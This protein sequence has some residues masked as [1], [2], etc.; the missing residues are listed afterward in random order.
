MTMTHFTPNK[1]ANAMDAPLEEL[2]LKRIAMHRVPRWTKAHGNT[3]PRPRFSKKVL[4]PDLEVRSIIESK[5]V[6]SLEGANGTNIEP[7]ALQVDAG[8]DTPDE[9]KALIDD[10]SKLLATS[11]TLAN[12]LATTQ[13]HAGGKDRWLFVVHAEESGRPLVAVFT[14][15]AESGV[16]MDIPDDDETDPTLQRVKNLVMAESSNLKELAIFENIGAT[17]QG[18]LAK[19]LTQDATGYFLQQFLGC[20]AQED[21]SIETKKFSDGTREFLNRH[22]GSSQ[23]KQRIERALRNELISD[24]AKIEVAVFREKHI[25]PE[26]R[27]GF[28]EVMKLRGLADRE[29]QKD[30]SR[31]P[32]RQLDTVRWRLNHEIQIEGPA[33]S[34]DKYVSIH[35]DQQGEYIVIRAS[36]AK[37]QS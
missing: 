6:K 32:E 31:I 8:N 24:E 33:A 26:H 12:L 20:K 4:I 34:M 7:D 5:I 15:Y 35:T 23:D 13:G 18:R 36:L 16:S 28:D 3:T 17:I 29:I 9:L 30:L 22:V 2:L 37:S 11:K 10:S 1:V 21:A 25:L 27:P 19:P 14:V